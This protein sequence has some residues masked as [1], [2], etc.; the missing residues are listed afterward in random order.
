MWLHTDFGHDPD[1]AIALSFLIEHGVMP[2]I[3]SITP[4][5][6]EQEYALVGFLESYVETCRLEKV[7]RVSNKTL[8]IGKYKIFCG[9]VKRVFFNVEE[10]TVD[11]ALIIGPAKN[12]GGK[13]RCE[14][15]FFQGG[16][17][18]NSLEP[19]EKFKGMDAVESF[20]PSGAKDDFNALLASADIQCK[21]YIGKN[22]CHG[23]TKDKLRRIWQPKNPLVLKF[24]NLLEEKKAM[25]DVLA[26]MIFVNK[27]LGIWE[28]AKPTWIGNKMTTTPTTEQIY[29][30]VGF[31]G[32]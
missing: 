21:Y 2:E 29:T 20:N 7:D 30:L 10:H 27:D 9:G 23:F 15:M 12:L 16:Y 11:K 26:A 24:W 19:L 18:P 6:A 4:G 3:I 14:E 25:H 32:E 5:Y 28:Q 1:D 22:I 13:I 31:V 17:S 8:D